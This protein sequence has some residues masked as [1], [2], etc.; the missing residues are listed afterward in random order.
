MAEDFGGD[1]YLYDTEDGPELN[2]VNGLI[3]GDK[4]FRT[5][6]YLSL[7]GGNKD[8]TGEVINDYTWWGNKLVETMENQKL[9]SRFQAFINSVP[10]TAKNLSIA[11]EKAQLDLKWFIDEGIADSVQVNISENGRK[12]IDVEIVISKS[13]NVIDSTVFG[14]QWGEMKNGV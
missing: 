7:F 8:D 14:L 11:E 3:Q 9:V 1:V 2:I 5:A 13:G 4:A 6:V 12:R 10:L